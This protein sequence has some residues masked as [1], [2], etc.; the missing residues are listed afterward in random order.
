MMT[1]S[2]IVLAALLLSLAS[3]L[4]ARAGA[5]PEA[6]QEAL[7]LAK[8]SVR[9]PDIKFVSVRASASVPGLMEVRTEQELVYSDTSG[10]RL[11][12]GYV[13]DTANHVDLTAKRWSELNNVD[14][15]SL[16]LEHAIKIVKGNGSRVFAAFEDPFCPYCQKFEEELADMTDLTLY[17]FLFPLESIHPGATQKSLGIWCASNRAGAWSA[18]MLKRA[19]PGDAACSGAP[20]TENSVLA[21]TL[22]V[23]GT[24][25]LMFGDGSRASSLLTKEELEHRLAATQTALNSK[26]AS[27]S[28]R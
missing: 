7:L 15:A 23:Q 20:V 1:L 4:P 2:R 19:D 25:T 10:D 17:V 11:F 6:K 3:A 8:L 26:V 22:H 21:A 24:P 28:T 5:A 16:P 14:F 9:F 27:S 18:W 13:I 12:V